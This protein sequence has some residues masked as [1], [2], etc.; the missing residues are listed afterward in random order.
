MVLRRS[1]Q[2]YSLK[3]SPEDVIEESKDPSRS[4]KKPLTALDLTV[5]GVGA[6][7]GAGIFVYAGLGAQIAGPHIIWSFVLV[8]FIC[9]LAGL[10]YAEMAA[11]I[12]TSGSAYAYTYS[13][14]GETLAWILGWALV[15]EYAV[16]AAAVAIGWSANFV[17]FMRG[18]FGVELPANLTTG[19]LAGGFINLPAI[20]L[21]GLITVVLVIGAK[22]SAKLAGV[23]VGIKLAIITIII[24]VG[25]FFIKGGNLSLAPPPS[26][27]GTSYSPLVPLG[28]FFSRASAC[29]PSH[30][31]PS[32]SV[33]ARPTR[34]RSA[35]PWG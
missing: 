1:L 12:P 5:L 27:S 13:A 21:V 2:R 33:S 24:A 22:E 15:L 28:P 35:P 19:F 18:V 31:A 14:L 17:G 23:M 8:G 25:S 3:K 4:L 9:A 32:T 34:R 16:G 20:V 30:G 10:A 7:I 6:I 26:P 11:A 29:S